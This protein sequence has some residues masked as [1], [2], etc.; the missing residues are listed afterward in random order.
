MRDGRIKASEDFTGPIAL[1]VARQT[2]AYAIVA[3]R[4]DGTDPNADPFEKSAYKQALVDC[5][6]QH[7]L[8]LVIDVHGMVTASP[9]IIA[10]GTGDGINVAAWPKVAARVMRLIEGR[11]TPFA[12]KHNKEIAFDGHYAARDANT[13]SATAARL[14][15]V[16]ALQIELSTLLRF[17][18]GIQGHTPP[19]ER[20][21]FPKPALAPELSARANPDPAAVEAAIAT[22]ADIVRLAC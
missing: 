22:L 14:C 20:N 2:G 18:G 7:G 8:K 10:L 11:L 4:F 21:P 6:R 19:G 12:D 3:T 5:V 17:P 13:V 1:E 16:A 9:A 15:D